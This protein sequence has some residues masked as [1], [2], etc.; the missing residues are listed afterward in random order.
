M[1]VYWPPVSSSLPGPAAN[2][3]PKEPWL[4]DPAQSRIR[5]GFVRSAAGME[6]PHSCSGVRCKWPDDGTRVPCD[7]QHRAYQDQDC[8]PP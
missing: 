4:T 2:P 5:I 3:S 8:Q 6:P 7:G 1:P